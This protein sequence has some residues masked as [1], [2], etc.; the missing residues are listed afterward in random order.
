[1]GQE[2]LNLARSYFEAK[3]KESAQSAE[4]SQ[5]ELN[6]THATPKEKKEKLIRLG[7]LSELLGRRRAQAMPYAALT[8]ALIAAIHDDQRMVDH[9]LIEAEL[10]LSFFGL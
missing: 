1:M 8:R 2:S 9:F 7:Q 3:A 10:K 5:P 6:S 4:M